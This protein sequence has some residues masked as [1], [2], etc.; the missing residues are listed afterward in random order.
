[1]P[2]ADRTPKADRRYGAGAHTAAAQRTMRAQAL[3]RQ[4]E[5]RRQQRDR[6]DSAARAPEATDEERDRLRALA[7]TAQQGLDTAV[8]MALADRKPPADQDIA[9]AAGADA[10][11]LEHVRQRLG[12]GG[13][14]RK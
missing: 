9:A 10:Y 2:R 6:A 12:G 1:M 11:E 3:L 4:I 7:R 8:M 13:P 5:E 14:R